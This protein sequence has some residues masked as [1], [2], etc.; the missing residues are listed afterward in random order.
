MKGVMSLAL[1]LV[2][3]G[4]TFCLVSIG[5]RAWVRVD[6][7]VELYEWQAMARRLTRDNKRLTRQW[8]LYQRVIEESLKGGNG[9]RKEQVMV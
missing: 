6:S 5:R 9:H 1:I 2:G 7:Q 3:G 8:K 4:L